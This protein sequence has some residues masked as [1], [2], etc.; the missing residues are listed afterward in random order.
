MMGVNISTHVDTLGAMLLATLMYVQL[1]L[2]CDCT[3]DA[4][5]FR[6]GR[7]VAYRQGDRKVSGICHRRRDSVRLIVRE[8]TDPPEATLSLAPER[9]SDV[10]GDGARLGILEVRRG[11]VPVRQKAP[12]FAFQRSAG[13]VIV[14]RE[15][16][17][18]RSRS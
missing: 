6:G 17:F 3:G 15:L 5:Q 13:R 7:L 11:R 18:G 10:L 16:T 12:I 14:G 4:S 8:H 2:S 1:Q 9:I